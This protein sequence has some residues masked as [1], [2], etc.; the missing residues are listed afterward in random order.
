MNRVWQCLIAL[1]VAVGAMPLHATQLD[2]DSIFRDHL[3]AHPVLQ[4]VQWSASGDSFT[5]WTP[6]KTAGTLT[7][8]QQAANDSEPEAILSTDTLRLNDAPLRVSRVQWSSDGR[9][10]LLTGPV[11]RSWDNVMEGSYYWLDGATGRITGIA[12]GRVLR[13]IDVS[14]DS[15]HIAYA[16]GNNLYVLRVQDGQVTAVTSDGSAD[17]FNG[18]FDYGSRMFGGVK[19]WH[20][21]PDGSAIAFWRLDA[22]DVREFHLVDE[23]PADGYNIV[24][25]LKYPNAGET[26]AVNQVGIYHLEPARIQWLATDHDPDDYLV[27]LRWAPNSDAVLVQQLSR[28]H[29]RLNVLLA[30]AQDG[31]TRTVI[32]D[33]DPAWIDVSDDLRFVEGGKAF[34]WT[35]ERSGYRHI[36][37]V[38]LSGEVR[39]LTR[40]DWEI[41]RLLAV[42]EANRWLYFGAKIDSNI[43]EP[44]YRVALDG[45]EVQAVSPNQGW[46]DWQFSPDARFA[47]SRFSDANTPQRIALMKADGTSVRPLASADAQGI[48]LQALPQTEFIR[49][50]AKDGTLIDGF[51]IKPSDFDPTRRYPVISYGYGNAGSQIVVNRWGTQRGPAQDL[52]HRYLAEQGYVVIGLDNRTTT[53]RGKAAKNLTYGYYGKY[54]VSDFLEAMQHIKTWDFIDGERLGFWGWSGGGYMAAALMTKG[55]GLFSTA[56]GVAPV[57]DLKR[58]QA[59]GVERWMNLP[60]K[61]PDGY[62]YVNLINFADQLQGNL[63]LIHGTGDDNVKFAFTLQFADALIKAGKDFDMMIYPN[64][65][66]DIRGAQQH[67]FRQITRYFD[68]HL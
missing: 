32:S 41:T 5:Y 28:D 51:I 40:G 61:N 63:L 15:R 24:R 64:E 12:D 17:I 37:R 8:W 65:H 38:D 20:W 50:P 66:H 22:S 54:A 7:V 16:E 35:S 68:L 4:D 59:V 9:G 44:V 14:P 46:H 13:A 67:V 10:A 11:S 39:A 60:E 55:D 48:N 57:I 19:A 36:Y 21:S 62:A 43:D 29:Q 52:W 27:N 1:V 42:D 47:I 31:R 34:L 2:L 18:V 30:N 49:V 53:G 56:V 25:P 6:G 23:L 3:L 45:G 58:Y 33:T 26:H